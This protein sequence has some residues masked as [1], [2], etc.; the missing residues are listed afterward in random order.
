[1]PDQS[2]HTSQPAAAG[3]DTPMLPEETI[4]SGVQEKVS[5]GLQYHEGLLDDLLR[6]VPPDVNT[7]PESGEQYD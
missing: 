5:S 7:I 2:A 6:G 3:Q 4:S 1:M